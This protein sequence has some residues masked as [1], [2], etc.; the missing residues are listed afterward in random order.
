[1]VAGDANLDWYIFSGFGITITQICLYFA[2][3]PGDNRAT[4]WTVSFLLVVFE[5]ITRWLKMPVP[6]IIYEI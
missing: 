3:F 4:K 5:I 6:L 2:Q 1:M